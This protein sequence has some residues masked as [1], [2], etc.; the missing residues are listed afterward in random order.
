MRGGSIPLADPRLLITFVGS[1][2][3]NPDLPD[4]VS[5]YKK[6]VVAGG[7]LWIRTLVAIHTLRQTPLAYFA[8]GWLFLSVCPW[9]FFGLPTETRMM[10]FLMPPLLLS[11][12]LGWAQLMNNP[13]SCIKDSRDLLISLLIV[14]GLFCIANPACYKQLK[15]LPVIWRLILSMLLHIGTHCGSDI[16]G[17]TVAAR[18]PLPYTDWTFFPTNPR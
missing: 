2:N 7:F 8:F 11:S 18:K 16:L 13:L 6:L 3:K 5:R 1:C 9:F 12:T 4:L 14:G 17:P 15:D 10:T